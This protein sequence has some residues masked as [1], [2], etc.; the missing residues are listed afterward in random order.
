MWLGQRK[1]V[2]LRFSEA[3]EEGPRLKHGALAIL[4][5]DD[6]ARARLSTCWDGRCICVAASAANPHQHLRLSP[7]RAMTETDMVR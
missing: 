1:L 6:S 3:M 7:N 2:M 5:A 4:E